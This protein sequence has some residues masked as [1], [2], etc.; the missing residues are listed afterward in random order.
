M[1]VFQLQ[2]ALVAKYVKVFVLFCL[3]CLAFSLENLLFLKMVV[4][5]SNYLR[6]LF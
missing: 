4:K 3:V 2:F 5:Y 1:N 6:I